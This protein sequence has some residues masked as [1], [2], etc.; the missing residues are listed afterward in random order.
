MRYRGLIGDDGWLS[1]QGRA[2]KQRVEALTGDLAAKPY[3]SLEPERARRAHGHAR[4]ARRAATRR[5]GLVD[6]A[7]T[8][9]FAT[10]SRGSRPRDD[11]PWG[12]RPETPAQWHDGAA[13]DSPDCLRSRAAAA[14]RFGRDRRSSLTCD[15]RPRS[16]GLRSATWSSMRPPENGA[17]ARLRTPR[18]PADRT[19]YDRHRRLEAVASSRLVAR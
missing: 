14:P 4:A 2:V 13:L 9:L 18:S 17:V 8:V 12:D 10:S 5:P 7:T 19:A 1:E 16:T 11:R 3:E 15:C 6:A